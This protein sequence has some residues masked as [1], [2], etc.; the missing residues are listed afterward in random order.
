MSADERRTEIANVSAASYSGSALAPESIAVAFGSGLAPT[1]NVAAGT[2]LPF[3]LGNTAV[4]VKDGAGAER[5]APLFHVSPTQINYQIPA[6]TTIGP[7]LI[8]VTSGGAVIAAGQLQIAAIAP[9]L[10]AATAGA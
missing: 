3:Y 9:G 5:L 10:F 4:I 6:G 7:A 8:T 2:P 1:V